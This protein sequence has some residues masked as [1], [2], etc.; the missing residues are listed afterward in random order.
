MSEIRE[1]TFTFH[2][3]SQNHATQLS[4]ITQTDAVG[5]L[6]FWVLLDL[7]QLMKELTRYFFSS[8]NLNIKHQDQDY[9]RVR[10]S[11]FQVLPFL[12]QKAPKRIRQ[13][14][15]GIHGESG[16][17][18]TNVPPA[19]THAWESQPQVTNTMDDRK[20]LHMPRLLQ[21]DPSSSCCFRWRDLTL[22]KSIFFIYIY[23][24]SSSQQGQRTTDLPILSVWQTLLVSTV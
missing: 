18:P 10:D 3:S 12:L 7:K 23:W 6:P 5:C 1:R 17:T 14:S 11:H 21:S 20:T 8:S 13:G 15:G 16:K 9:N 2:C 4:S 19:G 24:S 22:S